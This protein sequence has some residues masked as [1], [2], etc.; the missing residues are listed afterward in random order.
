MKKSITRA[1]TLIFPYDQNSLSLEFAALDY[2]EAAAIRYRYR[3]EGLEGQWNEVDSSER[4]VTYPG[5]PPGDYTFRVQA[6]SARGGLNA[7]GTELQVPLLPPWW[8]TWWFRSIGCLTLVGALF[9][10]YRYRIR[11]LQTA[12]ARLEAQIAER[13]R[14]LATARDAAERSN[15]AK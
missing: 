5:T 11:N 10:A 1:T 2:S 13:T 12:G 14:N 3:M 7:P 15:K 8:A 4:L 9:T 6:A